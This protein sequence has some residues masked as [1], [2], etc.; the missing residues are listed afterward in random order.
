MTALSSADSGQWPKIL[1]FC[2][3]YAVLSSL[4]LGFA[5]SRRRRCMFRVDLL[6]VFTR[7]RVLPIGTHRTT[8]RRAINR[9]TIDRGTISRAARQDVQGVRG[10]LDCAA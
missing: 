7:N 4:L 1:G 5:R 2:L 10:I 9:E 6:A 8:N 3:A